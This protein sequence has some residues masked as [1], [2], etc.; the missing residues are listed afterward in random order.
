M[1][2]SA[3]AA[4]VVT[5]FTV[6]SALA[7]QAGTA[8]PRT[9]AASQADCVVNT[10]PDGGPG[11]AESPVDPLPTREWAVIKEAQNA[12]SVVDSILDEQFGAASKE[13]PWKPLSNGL[14]GFTLDHR[15]QRLLIVV[16]PGLDTA[17]LQKVIDAALGTAGASQ[18]TA[19]VV[20]GCNTSADLMRVAG[21][22]LQDNSF[23]PWL[24]SDAKVAG[25]LQANDSAFHF[26]VQNASEDA[27]S[28]LEAAFPGLIFATGSTGDLLRQ[29][30]RQQDLAPH[31]GGSGI[32]PGGPH[33]PVMAPGDNSCTLFATVTIDA[34]QG[35]RGGITAGHCS[36]AQNDVGFWSADQYVG[37]I[38]GVHAY[39]QN[40]S[41]RLYG[42]NVVWAAKI[43]TN[44]VSDNRPVSGQHDPNLN[45]FL[46]VSGANTRAVCAIQV[47]SLSG[48]FCKYPGGACNSGLVVAE[49]PNELVGQGGDSGAPVYDSL[50]DGTVGLRAME[51]A[52]TSFDNL[53][54][55]PV[56]EMLN[57]LNAHIVTSS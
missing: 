43:Y 54:A 57:H 12:I 48:V 51:V 21:L 40:D 49:K 38:E 39:P 14:I 47:I 15:L 2:F 9:V 56:Q 34:H 11:H 52:G 25:Q 6:A 26:V 1:H 5:L 23:A 45:A 4:A 30:G 42:Q 32:G 16:D 37:Q 53:Y 18:I 36:D 35:D 20:A 50:G 19:T 46:C 3:K 28:D 13:N 22:T 31:W 55:E 29:G 41:A 44:P 7:S 10:E 24:G 17:S 33:D 27:I 8:S